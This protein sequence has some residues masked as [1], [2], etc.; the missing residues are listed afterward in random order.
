MPLRFG[1]RLKTFLPPLPMSL[2]T[3]KVRPHVSLVVLSLYSSSAC[4]LV[5]SK[6][7]LFDD[8]Y[9]DSTAYHA[10][11]VVRGLAF[12]LVLQFALTPLY[13]VLSDSVG[14]K[15]IFLSCGL[16]YTVVVVLLACLPS[17]YLLQGSFLLYATL[18]ACFS[19][20]F[21]MV[22]DVS[23]T[24]AFLTPGFGLVHAAFGVGLTTGAL[25]G[26]G[27]ATQH[28]AA[29]PSIVATAFCSLGVFLTS[30]YVHETLDS[31]VR[32]PFVSLW[33]AF[34]A[35]V[36]HLHRT[37][38]VIPLVALLYCMHLAETVHIT[39][40]FMTNYRFGWQLKH[41]FVFVSFQGFCAVAAVTV[42]LQSLARLVGS[43]RLILL[44][45]L[46]LQ[47]SVYGAAALATAGWQYYPIF[48]L[49][50]LHCV[51][52]PALRSIAHQLVSPHDYGALHSTLA[53]YSTA[54]MTMG[55]PLVKHI[56]R[57]S[58]SNDLKLEHPRQCPVGYHGV[59]NTDAARNCG[60]MP[61]IVFAAA[62]ALVA[63]AFV[64]AYATVGR[65]WSVRSRVV[66][67]PVPPTT[68]TASSSSVPPPPPPIEPTP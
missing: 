39:M 41:E 40:Y 49:G 2:Q 57:F 28:H 16:V 22:G 45:A 19:M 61:W 18:N 21:A 35:S 5:F 51:G 12:L 65:V 31:T 50:M 52:Y 6:P 1:S 4:M 58:L 32:K 68:P 24:T 46:A 27:L 17:K 30:K 36:R 67:G 33:R 53:V 15:P 11:S 63:V 59:L 48:G 43:N 23:T 26:H 60:G 54:A 13:G 55:E 62:A 8:V 66:L 20:G 42:G 7:D 14:R 44:G 47:T 37:P 9:H 38:Q 3:S 34:V 64:V 10:V 25:L 29:M 56:V